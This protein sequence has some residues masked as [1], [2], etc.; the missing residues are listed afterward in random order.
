MGHGD[1]AHTELE[2]SGLFHLIGQAVGRADDKGHIPCPAAGALCQ[3]LRQFIGGDLLAL[4]AHS[5]DSSTLAHIGKDGLSLLIQRFFHH[6]VRGVFLLDLF[7]RQFKDAEGGKGR[8][9]LLV[10]CHAL[11]EIFG[12]QL[13]HTDQVDILHDCFLFSG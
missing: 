1:A 6:G 5:H 11:G 12:V 4:D 7:L 9:T 8:Q 13:T 10:L 3:K 2:G